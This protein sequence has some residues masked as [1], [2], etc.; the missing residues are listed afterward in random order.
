MG[1]AGFWGEMQ[2]HIKRKSLLDTKGKQLQHWNNN[3][4]KI[5]V[6]LF[7]FINRKTFYFNKLFQQ[8]QNS[9]YKTLRGSRLQIFQ[10]LLLFEMSG[11]SE[12]FENPFV[13]Y[14]E[15]ICDK[16]N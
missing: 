3:N 4:T 5:N 14:F 13:K 7:V 2:F 1:A 16:K 10:N 11:Q 15:N 12:I 8:R 6:F 9:S